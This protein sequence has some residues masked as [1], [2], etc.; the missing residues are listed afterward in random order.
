MTALA[1][2]DTVEEDTVVYHHVTRQEPQLF[3]D[4]DNFAEDSSVYYAASK[5]VR[6]TWQTASANLC[7]AMF[8]INGTLDNTGDS[9]FRAAN[10]GN[11]PVFAHAVD[12]GTISPQSQPDPVVWAVG[13]VRDPLLTFPRISQN[14]TGFFWSAYSDIGSV[15]SVFLSN[16]TGAHDRSFDLDSHIIS[17]ASQISSEY[18]DIVSLATRQIFASMDITVAQD[19]DGTLNASDVKI[20]M[21][22]MGVSTRTNP[23]DVLYGALPALLYFNATIVRDM[24][25]PLLEAQTTS[26]YAAPDLGATY[27]TISPN[28]S[29]TSRLAVDNCGSMLIMVYAHAVKSGDGSLSARYSTTLRRW[30][31][32]LVNNSLN[33]P[34]DSITMDGS[35]AIGSSDLALKGILG[36]YSMGKIDQ[37]LGSNNNT[38]LDKATELVQN[39]EKLS[40]TDTHLVS[41]FGELDSWG[42][43]YNLFYAIWLNTDL[44]SNST[45]T[46]QADFYRQKQNGTQLALGLESSQQAT[47]YPHWTL[48]TAATVPGDKPEVRTQLIDP[49]YQRIFQNSSDFPLPMT[50]STT[51]GESLSGKSGSAVFGTSYGLLALDLPN[52]EITFDPSTTTSVTS[53]PNKHTSTS[54]LVG[55]VVGG[56]VGAMFIALLGAFW[57]RRGKAQRDDGPIRPRPFSAIFASGPQIPSRNHILPQVKAA[58]RPTPPTAPPYQAPV[59]RKRRLN[60]VF[61]VLHRP[62]ASVPAAPESSNGDGDLR[63]EVAQLRRELESVRH[64]ADPPPEYS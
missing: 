14:R 43:V 46:K 57:Y 2:W 33:P 55:G 42:L 63:V 47:V 40:A 51:T 56:V 18:A 13:V 36:V 24:L 50:Y 44:I 21:K 8:T 31:D 49:I 53:T 28:T 23:V 22:D 5:N 9:D 26:P 45:L 12:L 35:S 7:R 34:S 11:W 48:L 39:W 1:K 59:G 27:P 41:L 4:N 60:P 19:K 6:S 64:L 10:S 16:F 61:S 32:F 38:Y 37:A 20:F 17:A 52:M 54:G 58:T 25:E 62:R 3:Q 15:I 29:D 30:A